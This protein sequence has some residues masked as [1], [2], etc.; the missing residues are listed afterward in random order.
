MILL[1]L[2]QKPIR[3]SRQKS[4]KNRRNQINPKAAQMSRNDGGR[5]T[6]DWIHGRAANRSRK[7]CLQQDGCAYHNARKKL[8]FFA[9]LRGLQ[10]DQHQQIG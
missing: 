4:P 1:F 10:D 5:K 3:Q 6:S 9:A 7:H 2:R 8:D